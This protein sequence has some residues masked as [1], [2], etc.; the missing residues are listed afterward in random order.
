MDSVKIGDIVE[1]FGWRRNKPC[2]IRVTEIRTW[3]NYEPGIQSVLGEV[4]SPH[5][6]ITNIIESISAVDLVHGPNDQDGLAIESVPVIIK[7][8][9]GWKIVEGFKP[10]IAR[11]PLAQRL[12]E[13]EV[14]QSLD[15]PADEHSRNSCRCTA[16]NAKEAT[17]NLY[18][19][20][21]TES[22]CTITRID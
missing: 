22:G 7:K 3:N 8:K 19:V 6:R 11:E 1:G 21:K 17:G 16:T 5:G 14:D 10:K 13:L 4:I 2:R 20:T 9:G 15:I 12:R 18:R